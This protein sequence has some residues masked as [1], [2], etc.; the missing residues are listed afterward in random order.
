MWRR[1]SLEGPPRAKPEPFA[2]KAYAWAE[3]SDDCWFRLPL[4]AEPEL[5][6]LT[7]LAGLKI[8]APAQARWR[9]FVVPEG[10]RA[11][12][13]SPYVAAAGD[14]DAAPNNLLSL[15]SESCA[16]LRTA[17][18][19][20]LIVRPEVAD[21]FAEAAGRRGG[22]APLAAYGWL[23]DGVNPLVVLRAP[24]ELAVPAREIG[25]FRP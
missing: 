22:G 17:T 4:L 20:W 1:F 11:G 18:G 9:H 3:A 19:H 21:V 16:A 8:V 13:L 7:G 10:A 12:L 23:N 2:G 14:G 25:Y 6:R 15:A 5:A 24:A